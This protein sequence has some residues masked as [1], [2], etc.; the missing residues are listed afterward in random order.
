MN[1]LAFETISRWVG[2][3]ARSSGDL[4]FP[5]QCAACG[6]RLLASEAGDD[7]C[8]ECDLVVQGSVSDCQRC[9]AATAANVVRCYECQHFDFQFD[10]AFALGMYEHDLK[11]WILQ[12]KQGRE[13]LAAALGRALARYLKAR[14]TGPPP[15]IVTPIPRHWMAR[16]F[17]RTRHELVIAE[18]IAASW[19]IRCDPRLLKAVRWLR[20]QSDL[21]VAQRLTNVRRAFSVNRRRFRPTILAGKHVLLVDDVM[22][23]GA[24]ASA[25]ASALRKAGAASISVAVVGRARAPIS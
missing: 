2:Q 4:V 10:R 20:K 11:G 9:G 17:R 19:N 22:T 15:D 13:I 16:L 14:W 25:M 5:A 23:T 21:S 6:V 3:A 1:W 24:T 8:P 18:T 12:M 7:F